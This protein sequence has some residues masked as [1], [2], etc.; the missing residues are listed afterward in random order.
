[1]PSVSI[2]WNSRCFFSSSGRCDL[3][4][5]SDGDRERDLTGTRRRRALATGDQNSILYAAAAPPPTCAFG[6]YGDDGGTTNARFPSRCRCSCS[7]TAAARPSPLG[8]RCCPRPGVFVPL[9]IGLPNRL[10]DTYEH[11][12]LLKETQRH[13]FGRYREHVPIATRMM[14]VVVVFVLAARRSSATVPV[15]AMTTVAVACA[16][17]TKIN[18][19]FKFRRWNDN[20]S[21]MQTG[22]D[23]YSNISIIRFRYPTLVCFDVYACEKQNL[24]TKN[25]TEKIAKKILG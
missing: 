8:Y 23:T 17:Q 2:S 11:K 18:R 6:V 15:S 16:R 12:N 5:F 10:I 3:L 22:D 25:H 1:M 19:V 14:A 4:P 7:R 21:T 13:S 9:S 24:Y 20:S